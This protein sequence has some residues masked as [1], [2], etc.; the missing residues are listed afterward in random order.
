MTDINEKLPILLITES[1]HTTWDNKDFRV[2]IWNG[3]V[4]SDSDKEFE[5]ILAQRPIVYEG[6]VKINLGNKTV[7]SKGPIATLI[8]H[9]RR[10]A[11]GNHLATCD[12]NEISS[13]DVVNS[14]VRDREKSNQ[15]RIKLFVSCD[16]NG[17]TPRWE[18]GKLGSITGVIGF[19]GGR[20]AVSFNKDG[21]IIFAE[22]LRSPF[23][24]P[25]H[26]N[27]WMT[28]PIYSDFKVTKLKI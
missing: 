10:D 17:D 15:R 13:F 25:N 12:G 20:N 11:Q 28:N 14:V 2:S 7:E 26:P 23:N 22:G 4:H 24:D 16:R 8:V 9:G 3:P 27:A 21:L 5:K 18:E 1:K 19:S 6:I